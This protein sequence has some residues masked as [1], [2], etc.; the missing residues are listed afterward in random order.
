MAAQFSSAHDARPWLRPVAVA[1]FSASS[2]FTLV[3]SPRRAQTTRSTAPMGP[4]AVPPKLGGSA[5]LAAGP[6]F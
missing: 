2:M 3:C 5:R 1:P 4:T 6:F